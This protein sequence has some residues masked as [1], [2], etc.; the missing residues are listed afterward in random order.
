MNKSFF[1]ITLPEAVN[2]R[3]KMKIIFNLILSASS[4]FYQIKTNKLVTKM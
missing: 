4:V 2:H 1:I 3:N